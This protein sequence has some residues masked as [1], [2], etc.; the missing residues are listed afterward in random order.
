[1]KND[2]EASYEEICVTF[3]SVLILM[4]SEHELEHE[5]G[6]QVSR[7]GYLNSQDF[8]KP[9]CYATGEGL[10]GHWMYRKLRNND[11]N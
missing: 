8:S 2:I 5:H 3:L 9:P 1:M 4:M 10:V 7:R 6:Y 11:F